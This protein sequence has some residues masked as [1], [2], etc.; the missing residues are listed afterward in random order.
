VSED[1]IDWLRAQLDDDERSVA[2]ILRRHPNWRVD[3]EP[4]GSIQMGV[5]DDQCDGVAYALGSY[6]AEHIA[7]HD[8]ARVLREVASLRKIIDEHQPEWQTVEWDHDQNGKGHALCCRRCQNAEHSTW[9]PPIGQ[10]YGLPDGFVTPYV[11]APCTTLRLL[12]AI[13]S[14]RPGFQEAWRAGD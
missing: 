7:R 4:W 10:A 14:D 3:P 6:A 9:S 5:I 13:F 12:A 8:P 2:A 1:L 11:L